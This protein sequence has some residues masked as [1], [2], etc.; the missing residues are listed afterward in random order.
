MIHQINLTNLLVIDIETVPGTPDFAAFLF[1]GYNFC[2]SFVPL[3]MLNRRK[4][5]IINKL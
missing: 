1:K 3:K 2:S 5:L 4:L